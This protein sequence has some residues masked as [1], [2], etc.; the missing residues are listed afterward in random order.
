MENLPI[1]P[2]NIINRLPREVCQDIYNNHFSVEMRYKTFQ[3]EI[4]SL[5]SQQLVLTEE[6]RNQI[7]LV[8]E[9]RELLDYVLQKQPGFSEFYKDIFIKGRRHFVKIVDPKD[10]LALCWLYYLYH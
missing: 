5:D 10:D 4:R 2:N 8:L 3:N 1:P 7:K 6:Y 9:D